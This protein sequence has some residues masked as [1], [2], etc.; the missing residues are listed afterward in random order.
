MALETF[1]AES[2]SHV[3]VFEYGIAAIGA[4]GSGTCHVPSMTLAAPFAYLTQY[5]RGIGTHVSVIAGV[6]ADRV[7]LAAFKRRR[8]KNIDACGISGKTGR[9]RPQDTI[10]IVA[11]RIVT[12]AAFEATYHFTG[13]GYAADR[14]GT[15]RNRIGCTYRMLGAN[16]CRDHRTINVGIHECIRKTTAPQSRILHTLCYTE[17]NSVNNVGISTLAVMAAVAESY[18]SAAFQ[19]FGGRGSGMSPVTAGTGVSRLSE[20][21]TDMGTRILNIKSRVVIGS[22]DSA[23][24]QYY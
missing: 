4:T 2:L 10:L 16:G 6:V 14:P 21:G 18:L 13:I 22:T 11:M 17:I 15:P 1:S 24:I 9:L 23:F 19:Q 12:V 3:T 7:N 8:D 20:T 5:A